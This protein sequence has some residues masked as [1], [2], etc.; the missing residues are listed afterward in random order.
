MDTR[1]LVADRT[2]A[3][4]NLDYDAGRASDHASRYGQYLRDRQDWWDDDD[5]ASSPRSRRALSIARCWQIA[6]QPIM[7][8]PLVTLHPRIRYV[9]A[10][11]D[12]HPDGRLVLATELVTT[13]PPSTRE[14][15][16]SQWRSWRNSTHPS[17]GPAW[18][19]PDGPYGAAIRTALPVLTLR[20]T[21]HSPELPALPTG[22]AP[23]VNE[24]ITVVRTIVGMLNSELRPI[25]G[26]LAA[27]G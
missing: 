24:A 26:H 12:D 20:W 4:M 15:L 17:N 8:P 1:E 9:E 11:P 19:E 2:A 25:L 27:A 6:N 3:W 13:L 5:P 16:G 22:G 21:V 18:T 7:S 23:A 10:E 14:A